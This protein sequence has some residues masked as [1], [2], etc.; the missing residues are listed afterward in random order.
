[1]FLIVSEE[2]VKKGFNHPLVTAQLIQYRRSVK[3]LFCEAAYGCAIQPPLPPI[4]AN[5]NT[6]AVCFFKHHAISGSI[7]NFPG[8][9]HL[10]LHSQTISS[11]YYALI[12]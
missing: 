11:M 4:A 12:N 3:S 6:A 7:I 1:L 10:T 9:S 5:G 2:Q 8:T